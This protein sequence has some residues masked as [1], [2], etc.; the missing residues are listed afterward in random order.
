MKFTLTILIACTITACGIPSEAR[1]TD[2]NSNEYELLCIDGVEYLKD[3]TGDR[4][5]MAPHFSPDG[6]L[7]TCN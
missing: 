1:T 5:F 6:S 7:Y 3:S 2:S 4:G